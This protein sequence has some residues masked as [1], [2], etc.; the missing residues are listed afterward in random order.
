MSPATIAVG[1]DVRARCAACKRTQIHMITAISGKRIDQIQC[2]ACLRTRKYRPQESPDAPKRRR[3][4]AIEVIP[5]EVA[6]KKL[7]DSSTTKKTIVYTFDK[8]YRVHDLINHDTFGMGV[9]IN[10]PTANKARVAF[11]AGELLLICNR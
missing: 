3:Q 11:K 7:M 2:K 6:W 10:L 1:N 8:Q 5:P 9:V 4:G